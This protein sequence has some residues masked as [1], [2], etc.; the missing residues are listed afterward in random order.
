MSYHIIR[1]FKKNL[2]QKNQCCFL[3]RFFYK[4]CYLKKQLSK[5]IVEMYEI[6]KIQ[7]NF[8]SIFYLYI[9]MWK[10]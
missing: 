3:D 9:Y 2:K 5:H 4:L 6:K 8:Q 7:M 1:F 10:S